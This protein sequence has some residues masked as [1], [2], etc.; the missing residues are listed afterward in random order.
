[1][2]GAGIEVG[3]SATYDEVAAAAGGVTLDAGYQL[4]DRLF[5]SR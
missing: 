2:C 4:M 3:S 1:M 5:A